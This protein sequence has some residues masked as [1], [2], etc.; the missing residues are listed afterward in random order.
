[1]HK[2]ILITD[3]VNISNVLNK[4]HMYIDTCHCFNKIELKSY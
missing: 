2:Y 1:M 4:E 3:I